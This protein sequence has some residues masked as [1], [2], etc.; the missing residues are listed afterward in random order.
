M[1]KLAKLFF[2]VLIITFILGYS[3][4][5]AQ[6]RS[7]SDIIGQAKGF[8]AKGEGADN[9]AV[10]ISDDNIRDLSNF[11]FNTLFS[12]AVVVDFGVASVLGI[13]Y[14]TASAEGKADIKTSM[15]PFVV[16]SVIVFSAMAIWKFAVNALQSMN[17]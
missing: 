7:F 15:V 10:D 14:I 11:A 12:I 17:F 2:L 5:Y 6:A 8:I 3:K 9:G 1:K 13:K 4:S 16:I